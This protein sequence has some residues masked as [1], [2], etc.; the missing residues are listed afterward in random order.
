M[1]TH[2]KGRGARSAR[3][4]PRTLGSGMSRLPFL[5]LATVGALAACG[6]DPG[7]VPTPTETPAEVGTYLAD[8]PSWSAYTAD[9]NAPS[10]PPEPVGPP[11]NAG[12]D[13]VSVQQI[14][15]DGTVTVL[16]DVVYQC[17][18]QEYNMASNP[19][20]LV[21]YDPDVEILWPG[22]LIQGRSRKA[23]GSFEGL[24]IA[25]RAPLRVS[26]PSF[27]FAENFREVEGPNQATVGAAVGAI[28]GDATARGIRAASAIDFEMETYHS[29]ESFALSANL[30]GR[31]LGFSGS[32]GT[33]ISR[34][35]AE[36]TV[37][38]HY[39]QRMFTVVVEGGQ[40]PGAFF[41][42]DFT[43]QKLQEQISQGRMGP[44]NLPIYVSNVVYGR[45]MMFS[46]TST[47]SESD[48]RAT[49]NAAYEAVVGSVEL[50]LSAKQQ[51]I[52]ETAKIHV[53]TRGGDA[54]NV[55][56]VIRSGDWSQYFTEDAALSTAAPLSY[57]LRNLGDNSIAG[58]TESTDYSIRECQ[59]I[60]ASPGS[61]AFLDPQIE[62]A[63]FTGG[64]TTLTGDVNGD[65]RIDLIWNQLQQG[66]NQLYVGISAGDGTFQFSAPFAHPESPTEGWGNYSVHVADINGDA[67]AD[68]VW[69]YLG[70]DNKT[71]V[72]L[73]AGDGTFGT[74][75]ARIHF[76]SA[77]GWGAYTLLVGDAMGPTGS[78]DGLDDLNFVSWNTASLGVY[79]GMSEGDS[80]FD[81]RPWRPLSSGNWS[82][83]VLRPANLDGDGDMDFFFAHRGSSGLNR[84]YA[85]TS[86]GNDEWTLGAHNDH[87]TSAGS[88]TGYA[89]RMGD[90]RGLGS[91]AIIW[92][93]TTSLQNNV[94]VGMWNGSSFDYSPV[95]PAQYR[96]NP[97]NPPLSVE[98]GDV[99]GDG[100][101][102]L[103]WGSRMAGA[104]RTYV[105]LGEGDGTFDFA[106][107]SQLHPDTDPNWSQFRMYVADVNGDGRDDIIWNHPAATN[108]IYTAIG[109]N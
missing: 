21:M 74:P 104:N 95:E 65:G 50:D 17:T 105:S 37:T 66:T 20:E 62:D 42:S 18:E 96:D 15:D 5:T 87:P 30:S 38:A 53:T 13:T 77:N 85:V 22:G 27:A 49:L 45:M 6:E 83:Y 90:V 63:P 40:S 73:G 39:I 93:D 55:L 94:T 107:V 89:I 103:I 108:R 82:N 67:F 36:T 101:A 98:V 26:I 31:Y 109:K 64:V 46:F 8:L 44:D 35:A 25:E 76:D 86:D 32:V 69:N 84:V 16:P 106:T 12:A 91:E 70:D 60:P 102:D 56:D 33:D 88:W 3:S 19:E 81:F 10:Q 58:R 100:D 54:Q 24:P 57:T 14:E 61:F 1:R 59:A 29:E 68:L 28:I 41:S 43:E 2:R 80:Q 92:A 52:L 9:V 78:G 97:Q 71:F 51:K 34:D 79:G 75:S 48:I 23:L 99:D 7:G 72:G 11:V 4:T 47:A